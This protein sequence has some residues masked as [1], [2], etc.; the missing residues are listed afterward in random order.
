MTVFI[1][2]LVSL[3]VAGCLGLFMLVLVAGSLM[4]Q[5]KHHKATL[6][7]MDER[8]NAL[9][10]RIDEDY[11]AL[12]EKIDKDYEKIISKNYIKMWE[13]KWRI[14]P[15]LLIAGGLKDFHQISLLISPPS[16]D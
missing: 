16:L 12:E 7:K 9:V 1:N 14:I 10:K 13:K 3:L 11:K 6:E 5:E 4:E 8:F 2:L 15:G